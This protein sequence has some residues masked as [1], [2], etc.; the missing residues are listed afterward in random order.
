MLRVLLACAG[1][2]VAASVSIGA[3]GT[4]IASDDRRVKTVRFLDATAEDPE[5]PDI[6]SVVVSNTAGGF[7]TFRVV[8]P[9]RPVLTDDMRV[10][11]W[12]DADLDRRTGLSAI[13]PVP[14]ADFFVNWHE[15]LR[16]GVTLL[17][18]SA[19]QCRTVVS[20][21]LDA[22]YASGA[23]FRI[24]T[25]ELG[26]TRRFRFTARAYSDIYGTS[27]SFDYSHMRVDF[28]PAEGASWTYRLLYPRAR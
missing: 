22:T 5:A 9:N 8:V 11:L 14:G 17:R 1:V 26:E 12:I 18:C 7:L 25:G 28:A 20:R 27:N 3:G 24:A 2:L 4:T 6:T 13:G 16:P 23:T 19:A 15:R 21:T 10:A